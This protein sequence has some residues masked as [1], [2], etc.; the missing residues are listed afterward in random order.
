MKAPVN[1]NRVKVDDDDV[2]SLDLDLVEMTTMIKIVLIMI[3]E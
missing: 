1:G 2:E 3:V